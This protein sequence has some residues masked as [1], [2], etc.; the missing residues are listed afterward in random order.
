ML[1]SHETVRPA[2]FLHRETKEISYVGEP[3]KT[4]KL[5]TRVIPSHTICLGQCSLISKHSRGGGSFLVSKSR[6]GTSQ[7]QDKARVPSRERSYESETDS[8]FESRK[9]PR[10]RECSNLVNSRLVL[11]YGSCICMLK[12]EPVSLLSCFS[13]YAITEVRG[14]SRQSGKLWRSSDAD[15]SRGIGGF[16]PVADLLDARTP[17]RWC[18]K[19]RSLHIL[20]F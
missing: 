8:G 1:R 17:P 20:G 9:G 19:L 18:D 12:Q 3:L 4:T 10:R 15:F 14:S 16:A 5:I 2:S 11:A 7:A 6:F 13:R